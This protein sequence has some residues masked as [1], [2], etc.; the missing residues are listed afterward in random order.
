MAKRPRH[1][2]KEIEE[3]VQY[4]ESNGW[5]WTAA[6][7]YA[8]GRLWCPHGKRGGCHF[9]VWSTPNNRHSHARHI[10]RQV[11]RCPH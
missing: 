9:G 4:A 8:W 1:P 11:D 3:A 5:T 7:G 6:P 10:R 2:N